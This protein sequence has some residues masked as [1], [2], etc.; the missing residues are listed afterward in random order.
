[1]D[2]WGFLDSTLRTTALEILNFLGTQLS[3][4][5]ASASVSAMAVIPLTM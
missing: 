5:S 4:A 3:S 1:M 2:R